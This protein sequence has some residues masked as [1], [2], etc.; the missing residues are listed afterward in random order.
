MEGSIYSELLAAIRAHSGLEVESIID[1][2]THGADSGFG[3]F[4]YYSDTSE[5]VAANRS[6]VWQLL[7]QDAEEFGCESVPAF[8]ATFN[9]A[10]LASDEAGFDCLVAWYVLES[11]ARW[12]EDHGDEIEEEER[13][14]FEQLGREAGETA[15]TWVDINSHDDARALLGGFEE[16]DPALYDRLPSPDF[17]GQWADEPTWLDVLEREEIEPG[18]DHRPDLLDA[19][20][21]GYSAAVEEALTKRARAWLDL[22]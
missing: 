18:D 7:E 9:R 6:L 2:A 20:E 12:L 5:F 22:D 10:D 1:A 15:S 19:F 16:G 3:G 14:R 8:V 17:S 21:A 11:V 4:T 13:E